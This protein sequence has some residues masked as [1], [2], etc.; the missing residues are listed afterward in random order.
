MNQF[1]CYSQHVVYAGIQGDDI[2]IP[3]VELSSLPLFSEETVLT[4]KL[5]GANCSIYH[6]NV[7]DMYTCSCSVAR[8]TDLSLI[9]EATLLLRMAIITQVLL[10]FLFMYMYIQK[11]LILPPFRLTKHTLSILS[12]RVT[13]VIMY[14]FVLKV[15]YKY[16]C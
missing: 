6:G 9:F 16:M 7:S 8:S 2:V 1:T 15:F 10:I 12:I 5:D 4:E 14:L 13:C 11:A 3:E